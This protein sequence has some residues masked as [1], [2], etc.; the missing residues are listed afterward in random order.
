MI[1]VDFFPTDTR[2]AHALLNSA[3][4]V[5]KDR[6]APSRRNCMA[7]RALIGGG[8]LLR[9]KSSSLSPLNWVKRTSGKERF[10]FSRT[11]AP[12]RRSGSGR[13]SNRRYVMVKIVCPSC[14]GAKTGYR[15]SCG[16]RGC[17]TSEITC[18]FCKG[19]G[20]VSAEASERWQRGDALRKAR[21]ERV[22][23]CLNRPRSSA[24]RRE[25]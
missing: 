10:G 25:H 16:D 9:I 8:A 1:L 14:G 12:C 18:D 7:T 13:K 23:R 19:E 21:V 5:L 6:F 4:P 3:A 24:S 20:Q 15:I 11:R 17:R 22:S 2:L